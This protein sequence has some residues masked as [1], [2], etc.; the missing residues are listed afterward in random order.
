MRILVL[1]WRDIKHPY[2]GGAEVAV[3]EQAKRWV[4]W[5][6][7]VTLFTSRPKGSLREDNIDGVKII[8]AGGFY[9]VYIRA[10][11]EYLMHIG[12]QT[13]VILESINGM[14]FFIS[15]Y[16]KK[17]VVSLIHHVHKQMFDIE[18]GGILGKIGRAIEHISPIFFRSHTVICTSD[19][20]LEDFKNNLWGAERK[21][22]C[23]VHNGVDHDFYFPGN[24]KY[25]RPTILY[26]GRIKKYKR[27]EKL[28]DVM[29]SIMDE[30]N[31]VRLLV[32]GKGDHFDAVR[33]YVEDRRLQGVVKFLGY[34][35]EFKKLDLYQKSWVLAMPSLVEGWGLNIIE[36]NACGTPCV[37]Y[38]VKGLKDSICEGI[39]GF[40]ADDD[41]NFAKYII[42]LLKDDG[43][44]WKMSQE[45]IRWSKRFSWDVTAKKTL[46]ILEEAL[47]V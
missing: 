5:G 45:A 25:E 29:P 18:M 2:A 34:V 3:H 20:T 9:T 33:S 19:S 40:L 22:A 38:R 14:P 10:A 4:R 13:D 37:G 11:L 47:K 17:P 46:C 27:L 16:S 6:H 41:E 32:A 44:R 43:L 28:I 15:A 42:R 31:G 21:R 12:K 8:R 24:S 23:V 1:N 39:T 7:K 30:V 35:D 26:L 36:A